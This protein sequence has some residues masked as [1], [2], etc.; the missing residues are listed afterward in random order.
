MIPEGPQL[1]SAIVTLTSSAALQ[2]RKDGILPL[3]Y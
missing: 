2:L 1:T 3:V